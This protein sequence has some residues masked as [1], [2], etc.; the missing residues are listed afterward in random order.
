VIPLLL[1]LLSM[2]FALEEGV[3]LTHGALGNPLGSQVHHGARDRQPVHHSFGSLLPGV[4][5]YSFFCS[6]K[7]LPD[8][9]VVFSSLWIKLPSLCQSLRDVQRVSLQHRNPIFIAITSLQRGNLRNCRSS[10]PCMRVE[11]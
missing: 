10:Y 8:Y 4:V 9:P 6:I 2:I 11:V 7:D 5:S 1:V 3:L